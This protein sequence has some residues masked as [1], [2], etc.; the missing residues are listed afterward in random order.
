MRR[1]RLL[2]LVG[3]VLLL[4]VAVLILAGRFIKLPGSPAATATP[5]GGLPT[6]IAMVNVVVAAQNISRGQIIPANQVR[7]VPWP[8]SSF[9]PSMVT[10]VAQV[11]GKIARYDIYREQPI[12]ETMVVDNMR[13]LGSIGSDAALQIQPG[14]VAM[15]VPMTRL[16]GVA[17]AL[18][19]GDQNKNQRIFHEALAFFAR[20]EQHCTHLLSAFSL[21]ASLRHFTRLTEL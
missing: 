13:E 21:G 10:D 18:A 19:D 4:G 20:C 3:L 5:E 8:Q 12:H 2:I 7:L 16:S 11:E 1:S 6:P 17:F 14:L 15:A 9:L